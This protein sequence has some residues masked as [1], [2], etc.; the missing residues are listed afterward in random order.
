[1]NS[2]AFPTIPTAIITQVFNNPNP[3]M[4]GGDGKHKGIDY[5]IM[6]NN[7]VYACMDGSVTT[8]TDN[9][10][11]YGR[12]V[13]ITHPGGAVSIYGHLNLLMVKVGDTVTAGQQI[14]LSGGD[15]TDKIPGDGTSTGAHLHWE[16]RPPGATGTDQGAVDPLQYCLSQMTTSTRQAEVTATSGL[17]IRL[18]PLTG[19]IL[20]TLKRRETVRIVEVINGW[21]RI[22]SLRPEWCSVGFL[23]IEEQPTPTMPAEPTDAQKLKRLWDAH[24]ELAR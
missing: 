19:S 9:A 1:M 16:I 7:P 24:P 13:R 11:G 3:G 15:P 6:T 23:I 2:P 10:T 22:H 18:A 12:H 5:G 17:Y 21:A 4:Y 20:Y 14:G 8:A